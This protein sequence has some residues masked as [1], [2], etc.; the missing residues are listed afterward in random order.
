MSDNCPAEY[1]EA[2][3]AALA[4]LESEKEAA[5]KKQKEK[6]AAACPIVRRKQSLAEI[7][8][9]IEVNVAAEQARQAEKDKE[10]QGSRS[11]L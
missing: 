9:I 3:I 6:E 8:Q 7:D 10:W 2:E 1:T 5:A 11:K 4:V